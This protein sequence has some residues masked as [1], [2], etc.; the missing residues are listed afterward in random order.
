MFA[1]YTVH[2]YYLAR[3]KIGIEVKI[4]QVQAQN[5]IYFKINKIKSK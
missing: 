3:I 1:Q 2:G 5:A 4:K